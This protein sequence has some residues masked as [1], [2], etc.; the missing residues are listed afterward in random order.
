MKKKTWTLTNLSYDSNFINCKWVYKTKFNAY[1]NF[2][3]HKAH[4]VFKEFHQT[5]GLDYSNTFN[6][7]VKPITIWIILAPAMSCK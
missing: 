4:L 6:P 2:Q 3:R 7:I 5:P 1:G